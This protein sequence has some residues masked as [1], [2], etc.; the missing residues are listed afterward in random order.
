M[1]RI[2]VG[3][4]IL[5]LFKERSKSEPQSTQAF[6]LVRIHV[7]R[8][9]LAVF[10]ERSNSEPQREHRTCLWYVYIYVERYLMFYAQS[11]AKGHSYQGDTK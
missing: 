6:P 9:I 10:K 11:T 8:E 3:R 4:E 1:V 7:G 2:H 5:D